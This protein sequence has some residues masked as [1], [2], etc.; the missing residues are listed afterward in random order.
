MQ[1]FP[2]IIY[3]LEHAVCEM[4][5]FAILCKRSAGA[6]T[7]SLGDVTS[8][9]VAVSSK[10]A[11]VFFLAYYSLQVL[12]I[13]NIFVAFVLQVRPTVPSGLAP[14]RAEVHDPEC[15]MQAFIEEWE[16][17]QQHH[18]HHQRRRHDHHHSRHSHPHLVAPSD[19]GTALLMA[20]GGGTAGTAPSYGSTL[21]GPAAVWS[22]QVGGSEG[23]IGSVCLHGWEDWAASH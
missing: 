16:K 20:P 22:V 1:S 13:L 2:K 23:R 5:A 21:G 8:G 12:V 11:R 4:L 19:P 7:G 6:W 17:R 18:H 14:G 9:F 15:G 3:V 10:W